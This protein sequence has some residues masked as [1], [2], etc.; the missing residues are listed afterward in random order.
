LATIK[1]N[2][3]LALSASDP[4]APASPAPTDA[5]SSI[6][7]TTG[8]TAIK[9]VSEVGTASVDTFKQVQIDVQAEMSSQA[10][11]EDLNVS[12]PEQ[13]QLITDELIRR[14]RVFENVG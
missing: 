11:T 3:N 12:G 14:K 13:E 8:S 1:N 9:Y 6:A 2:Q 7:S 5:A 4:V 10:A